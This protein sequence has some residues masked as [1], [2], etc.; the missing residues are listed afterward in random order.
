MLLQL[1]SLT[2]LVHCF[3]LVRIARVLTAQHL[4]GII[5]IST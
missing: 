1:N 4:A 5:I 2:V 3:I